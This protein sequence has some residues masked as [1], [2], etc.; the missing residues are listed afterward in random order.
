MSIGLEAGQKMRVDGEFL[1]TVIV[2]T[3]AA[4][5]IVMLQ[6]PDGGTT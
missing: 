3:G 6:S 5:E 4:T 2:M 1:D